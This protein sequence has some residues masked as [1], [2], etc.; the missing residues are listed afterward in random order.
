[1][2]NT[3]FDSIYQQNPWLK[4]SSEPIVHDGK[5][6]QRVQYDFLTDPAW[7][8]L[9]TILVGPRQAGK[10]TLG[11]HLCQQLIHQQRYQNL[12]YLNC[13]YPEIRHWLKSSV[14]LSEAAQA[15]ALK[16]YI[17]FIDEVQRLENP[18]LLLKIIADLKLPIKMLASG[19]SQL[20]IKSKIQ[21][22]LTGRQIESVILPLSSREMDFTH[23][24][25][26]ILQYGSYPQVYL[27]ESRKPIL[28]QELF[29]SYL[30]KD[31]IEFLRVGK[32][33]VILQLLGLLAHSC[34]QLLNF[35]QLSVDCRVNVETIRHY[36]DI[37]E[38]TYVIKTI[39]PFV[40][41][42]RTE[43]TSNPICYFIDNGFR[44]QALNNFTPIE[45][46]T[47][48][49]LLVQNFVFQEIYKYQLQSRKNWQI[50][51]WRT[52]GGAEVDFVIKTSFDTV[53]PIEVK[54]RNLAG[55]TLSR[56]YRSF[57]DSYQPAQ[58]F[59]ITKNQ[60]GELTYP[61]GRIYFIPFSALPELFM[62]L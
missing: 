38:K 46:R 36:L 52:K 1:M 33:E 4:S 27:H 23:Q 60:F 35:Q 37:L 9:W 49:G 5:Y 47:D 21:E 31:I 7:D 16:D 12:L 44:N 26:T 22:H 61:H 25:Q 48:G 24:W 20:E 10:T 29:N 55:L 18:G 58:G 53:I 28:L 59:V 8:H 40:G 62:M 39:K 42:K 54:F 30:Q 34:G 56:G 13:D 41:N 57:L 51:Y 6:I 15:F 14:F 3:L 19:S 17:L 11:K 43:L 50:C 45:S 2:D 32:P